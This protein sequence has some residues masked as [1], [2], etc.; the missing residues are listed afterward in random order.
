M[1]YPIGIDGTFCISF[2]FREDYAWLLLD[3]LLLKVL[4]DFSC[5]I[6]CAE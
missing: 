1:T 5:V 6:V 4:S 2:D 3:S